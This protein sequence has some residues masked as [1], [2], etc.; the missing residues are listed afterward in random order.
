MASDIRHPI[1]GI[2]HPASE[3]RHPNS[4]SVRRGDGTMSPK[5][6]KILKPVSNPVPFVESVRDRVS[7]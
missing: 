5:R 2:R 7:P 6:T 3:F 4:G 1:S